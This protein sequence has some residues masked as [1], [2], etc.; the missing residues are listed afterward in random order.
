M[1]AGYRS[2]AKARISAGVMVLLGLARTADSSAMIS[3]G[4][5][6]L[7][8][9]ERTAAAT[10]QARPAPTHKAAQQRARSAPAPTGT[11]YV[12][13][14][15]AQAPAPDPSAVAP[16]QPQ[17]TDASAVVLR[18]HQDITDHDWHAAQAL[19]GRN[20]AAQNGQTYDSWVSDLARRDRLGPPTRD[21]AGR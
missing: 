1:Q 7:A 10:T 3:S 4:P 14:P 18:Y 5:R 6:R 2:A 16:A 17:L 21:P 19:G 12:T 20:I 15:P 11:V 9:Q 8:P 13:P